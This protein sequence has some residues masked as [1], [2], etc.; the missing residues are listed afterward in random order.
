MNNVGGLLLILVF[1]FCTLKFSRHMR[2]WQHNSHTQDAKGKFYFRKRKQINISQNF[3]WKHAY[4][5]DLMNVKEHV[6][7]EENYDVSQGH[8]STV[9]TISQERNK[10]TREKCHSMR[11]V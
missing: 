10:K 9:V 5:I 4:K 3:R 2:N 7:K 8:L 1:L 11:H 6:I